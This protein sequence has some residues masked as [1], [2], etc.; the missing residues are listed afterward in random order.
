VASLNRVA[1][2]AASQMFM[3]AALK[4]W[5]ASEV[6]EASAEASPTRASTETPV[7]EVALAAATWAVVAEAASM[8]MQADTAAGAAVIAKPNQYKS[9]GPRDTSSA[10][11]FVFSS[12]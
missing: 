11:P 7:A 1:N 12:H 5:A 6:A 9:I 8:A 4:T 10:H 2:P 3:P